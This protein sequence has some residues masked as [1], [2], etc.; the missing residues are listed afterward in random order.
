VADYQVR[1]TVPAEVVVNVIAIDEEDA[2]ELAVRVATERVGELAVYHHGAAVFLDI[3]GV[4]CE[5]TE[6]G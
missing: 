1:W 4:D 6:R 5:V 2:V 3:D